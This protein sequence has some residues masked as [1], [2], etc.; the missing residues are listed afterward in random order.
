MTKSLKNFKLIIALLQEQHDKDVEFVKDATHAFKTEFNPYDNSLLVNHIIKELASWFDN[1]DLA[2]GEI[3]RFMYELDFGRKSE[4]SKEPIMELWEILENSWDTVNT[5]SMESDFTSKV[6]TRIY[7][8]G[9]SR[10]CDCW[11]KNDM[12]KCEPTEPKV[13]EGFIERLNNA[14][15]TKPATQKDID[16]WNKKYRKG[17]IK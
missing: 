12:C 5:K 14:P 1:I 17:Q 7:G 6:K 3:T 4:G 10:K 9:G 15:L 11:L 8:G 13:G 2:I 16:E